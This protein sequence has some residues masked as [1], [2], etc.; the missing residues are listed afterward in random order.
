MILGA[1]SNFD[2]I[3][4]DYMTEFNKLDKAGYEK[5]ITEVV[6]NRVAGKW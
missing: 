1:P 5:K 2:K 3:W 4:N 6:Q